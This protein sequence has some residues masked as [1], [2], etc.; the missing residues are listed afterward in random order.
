MGG[1]PVVVL[2]MASVAGAIRALA[3]P[4]GR[5][6]LALYLVALLKF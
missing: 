2:D 1:C 5:G 3:L 4:G 6:M